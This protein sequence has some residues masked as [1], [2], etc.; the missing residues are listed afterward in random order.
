MAAQVEDSDSLQ[1]DIGEK[2]SGRRRFL[3]V[4]VG[5]LS[6]VATVALAAPLVATLIGP[7]YRRQKVGFASVGRLDALPQG[8]PVNLT[9]SYESQ[10]AYMRQASVHDVWVVKH[11]PTEVTVFS[12]ICTH[13]GCH[14]GWDGQARQFRCPCHGSVF[15]I[16]GTVLAGPAP[17]P[18]D[19]LPSRV[20]KGELLVGWERF[21]PG[22]RQKVRV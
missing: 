19:T 4:A 12:P 18:L 8:E 5:I 3:K 7:M 9:F 15:S 22:V 13:L 14:Y 17:R 11:S 20:E 16:E 21:E 10:E 6:G 1:Q 2:D